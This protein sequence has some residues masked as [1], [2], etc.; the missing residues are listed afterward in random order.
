MRFFSFAV[1]LA[2]VVLCTACGTEPND[3]GLYGD[4]E[5]VRQFIAELDEDG[6]EL[7]EKTIDEERVFNDRNQLVGI[8]T[9]FEGRPIGTT[10][11]ELHENGLISEYSMFGSGGELDFKAEYSNNDKG[12]VCACVINDYLGDQKRKR[13]YSLTPDGTRL[14][15]AKEV[16]VPDGKTTAEFEYDDQNRT[17]RMIESPTEYL[18]KTE[19]LLEYGTRFFLTS[20]TRM[21]YGDAGVID[22]K[23]VETYD[24]KGN[25]L[26]E[27]VFDAKD[28]LI[29]RYEYEYRAFDQLGNWI[30][31]ICRRWDNELTSDTLVPSSILSREI[32]YRR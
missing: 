17:V 24:G 29:R 5:K 8:T 27:E 11:M 32:T 26:K 30:E 20:Y 23:R 28:D 18:P 10:E 3:E 9:Y 16:T 6:E 2:V 14:I 4:V 12:V 13:V 22:E 15:G 31:C 25:L 1:V 19:T 21:T 7:G